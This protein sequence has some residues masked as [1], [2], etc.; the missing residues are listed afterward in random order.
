MSKQASSHGNGRR[1]IIPFRRSE[2]RENCHF[3]FLLIYHK[4]I[5]ISSNQ[6]IVL[7]HILPCTTCVVVVSI[8]QNSSATDSSFYYLTEDANENADVDVDADDDDES[9]SE[10]SETRH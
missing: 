5:I 7:T 4:G 1:T 9:V 2:Q 6:S 8:S 10:Y 3:L